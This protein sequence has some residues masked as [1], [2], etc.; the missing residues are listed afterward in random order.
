[1]TLDQL[2]F[3]S[4]IVCLVFFYSSLGLTDVNKQ[5]FDLSMNEDAH[6]AFM[7]SLQD[8]LNL[9]PESLLQDS[10]IAQQINQAK[11]VE[12][13]LKP[14]MFFQMNSKSPPLDSETDSFFQSLQQK[15][16]SVVD[17]TLILEQLIT[18]FG[19]TKNRISQQEELV[20]SG[21][22][23]GVS[24]KTKLA[25]RMFDACF[26]TAA[27]SLLLNVA[28]SSVA[29]HQEITDLIKI[30]VESGR[31]PGRELSRSKARLAEAKA[32]KLLLATNQSEAIA[33]FNSLLPNQAT[34]KQF[35][36]SKFYI[37]FDELSAINLAQTENNEVRS[38]DFKIK[39]LE[40]QLKSIQ[41]GKYPQV[42]AEIRADKYDISNT[43]DYNLIGAVKFNWDLYQGR[44]RR[45]QEQN[46]REE[47]KAA[48]FEKQAL[49]RNVESFVAANLAELKQSK[50]RLEAFA[51]A[52]KANVQSREQLKAQFFAANVSLLEL[53]QSERDYLEAAEA[54][55]LNTKQ[56][57][58]A[59]HLHLFYTGTLD[60]YIMIAQENY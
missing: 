38:L 60:S 57:R 47:I 45:I 34:C 24:E 48:T 2:I 9:H 7:Q 26:N 49:E 10:L 5:M 58:M 25:L 11:I 18:D 51:E 31:A 6:S 53:L 37:E 33:N 23:S 59:E 42:K 54:L 4:I 3:K 28:D 20:R 35:P 50:L 19:Q 21:R 13:E 40:R 8:S 56:V 16:N 52:Y 46:S 1:M 32:K 43:D 55:V 41:K 29:R 44:K 39:S 30:R 14:K 22:A 17:Q 36:L 15:N 12:T 27:Y